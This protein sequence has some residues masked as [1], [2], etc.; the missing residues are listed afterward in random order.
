MSVFEHRVAAVTGAGSGIG[1]A[2]ALGLARRGARLAVSDVDEV[3]LAETVRLARGLGAEPHH[4]RVDVTDRAA[5]HRY[6]DDVAVH[7]GAVHQVYNNAGIGFARTV[8]ESEFS[9]YERVFAVNLWGVIHGTKAF[10]PHVI[11]SGDGHVVNISSLNG[12]MAQGALSHYCATKYAVR[13]FSEALRIEMLAEG[14]PVRVTVVHPG[15]VRTNIVANALAQAR[16]LDLPITADDEAHARLMNEK[17]LRMPPDTAADVILKGVQRDRPR[18]L[19]GNDAKVID[20][21]VR[22]FP[23]AYPR[24]LAATMRR[25]MPAAPADREPAPPR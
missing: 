1:R 17:I 23:G 8:L 24:V 22:A 25:L 16:A 20:L 15:G 19:V 12:Y 21:V 13:A 9:D 3:G 5:V 10:L 4:A 6:A 18:V 2:L 14:R 11:A 7:F